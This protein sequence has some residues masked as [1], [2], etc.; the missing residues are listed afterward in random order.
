MKRVGEYRG[1]PIV[2]FGSYFLIGP[3]DDPD[4]IQQ[5]FYSMEEIRHY[6]DCQYAMQYA[7]A[8]C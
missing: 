3:P 7:E 5:P 1:Y 2:D 8:C 4:Y 6:V